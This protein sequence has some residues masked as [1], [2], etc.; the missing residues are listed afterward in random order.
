MARR[1]PKD[2]LMDDIINALKQMTGERWKGVDNRYP[3]ESDG[4]AP[5]FKARMKYPEP[6]HLTPEEI[7]RA[8]GFYDR[9]GSVS[10]DEHYAQM[11][12]PPGYEAPLVGPRPGGGE[13]DLPPL[14]DYQPRSIR[15]PT[16]AEGYYGPRN[17]M[18]SWAPDRAQGSRPYLPGFERTPL[19]PRD[20][21]YPAPTISP[22]DREDLEARRLI[23]RAISE[24]LRD[25]EP[26]RHG[27]SVR[28]SST[29]RK[30]K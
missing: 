25:Q 20:E 27:D 29:K 13:V 7:R 5:L 19:R 14:V 17:E 22:E 10:P 12:A 1:T 16:S 30:K 8:T 28:F 15:E 6:P 26:A 9:P 11:Q 23:Q 21:F 18:P 3:W 24:S 2:S 4:E